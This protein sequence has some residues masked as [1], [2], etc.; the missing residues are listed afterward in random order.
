METIKAVVENGVVTNLVVVDQ[1]NHTDVAGVIVTG[2]CG[3]GWLYDGTAFTKPVVAVDTNAAIDAQIESLEGKTERGIRE[4]MLF[5]LV[6]EASRLGLT[7][8]QLYA[9]NYGYKK[10]KDLDNAIATLRAQRV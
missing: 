10:A 1:N 3:I 6:A 2:D 4:G 5:L 9:A 7:E 8:P